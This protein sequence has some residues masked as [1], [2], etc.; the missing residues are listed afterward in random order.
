MQRTVFPRTFLSSRRKQLLNIYAVVNM[1]N[2]C[3]L[4]KEDKG[5]SAKRSLT[6]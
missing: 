5:Y 2:L 1:V 6:V 4:V 3:L